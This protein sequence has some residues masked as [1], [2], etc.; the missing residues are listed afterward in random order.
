MAVCGR[1]C[2]GVVGGG[3]GV[4]GGRVSSSRPCQGLQQSLSTH[5]TSSSGHLVHS[6]YVACDQ[7]L[8]DNAISYVGA[9]IAL[10]TKRVESCGV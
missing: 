7:R 5:H 4:A 9:D 1:G 3:G 2:E 10:N 8:F 6:S